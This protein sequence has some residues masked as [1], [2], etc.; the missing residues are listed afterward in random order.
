MGKGYK[1][2]NRPPDR[3][4]RPSLAKK[5]QR[6]SAFTVKFDGKVNRIVTPV[7][8]SIAFDPKDY[9]GKD[10]PFPIYRKTALWDTG[11]TGS[12]LTV[13]TVKE[14]GLTPTGVTSVNHAGGTS[15]SNTYLV[16]F[17]LPNN[18]GVLGV[19]ASECP[20]IVGNFGAIIGM[21]IITQGDLALTN[22]DNKTCMSFRI[23]SIKTIDYVAD[24]NPLHKPTESKMT[25]NGELTPLPKK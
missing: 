11:A 17:L 21:D 6:Y 15:Q 25:P 10:I 22:V 16:N 12:V 8:I 9:E 14:M 7:G 18:V 24:I 23:P 3:I 20:S 5:N 19:R 13:K 2:H 4:L 1:K